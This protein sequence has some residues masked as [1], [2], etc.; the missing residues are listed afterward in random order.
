MDNKIKARA[1]LR[2]AV[3]GCG[4]VALKHL[5][6]V[7]HHRQDLF[8]AGLVAIRPEAAA[9]LLRQAGMGGEA[10]RVPVYPSLDIMLENEKV[11]LVAITTPSGSHFTLAKAALLAGKHVL[12]EKPLTLSVPEADELLALA[13]A[14]G[15]Q[16]AVGHIYRYFPVVQALEADL[17]AG[18]F[19]RV[20]YG[21][22]KVR[23]GHDQAY[24]DAAAWRGTWAQ[25]GGA[26]MNQSIH[27]LDLMT[28]LLGGRVQAACGWIDRQ[29]HQMEAEDLGLALFRLDNGTR[30]LLEGTTNTD[31][32]RPEAS[33]TVIC[34][35]GD[36]RAGL[37]DGKPWLD[38]T[39]CRGRS[40]AGRYLRRYLQETWQ[41]GGIRA[42][43]QLKNPHTA[44][45]G[46]LIEAIRL[47]RPPLADGTSGREAV[48]AVLALYA[49]ARE[50]KTVLLPLD[51]FSLA[52][53][54]GF[55]PE[56]R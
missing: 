27:A 2:C 36:I 23:W 11:D 44:L 21:D 3:V 35:A 24:Y 18:R 10:A 47:N 54:A 17:R 8:L 25:D 51:R 15:L 20:L 53:M 32:R 56:Q 13:R 16:I 7:R 33:F 14:N 55:F 34:S 31:H 6:A 49:A 37:R 41:Q 43:L 12:V 39:D 52:D 46:D 45:Y 5:N 9:D 19:G 26:L 28:W 30:L 4:K 50:E 42:L 22:V 48:A 38:I 29:M 1:L 40:L